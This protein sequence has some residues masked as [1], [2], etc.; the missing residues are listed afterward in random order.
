MRKGEGLESK[1]S[2]E[3]TRDEEEGGGQEEAGQ[4]NEGVKDGKKKEETKEGEHKEEGETKE[5][6]LELLKMADKYK[7]ALKEIQKK[8]NEDSADLEAGWFCEQYYD[9]ATEALEET[10]GK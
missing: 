1:A 3:A 5:A 9:I 8:G 6:A 10:K 4:K 2:E 7:N